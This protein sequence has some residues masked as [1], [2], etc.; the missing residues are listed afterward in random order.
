MPR[1]GRTLERSLALHSVALAGVLVALIGGF[2]TLSA[3]IDVSGAVIA[4]G[5]LVVESELKRIQHP[6]GGV[7]S[8]ILVSE[9]SRVAKDEVLL[10][11]DPTVAKA[12]L[13]AVTNDLWEL[14]ARRARLEAE[15]D[16][17][18]EPGFTPA[19]LAAASDPSL[20]S[21]VSGEKTLFRYRTEAL[22]GQKAQLR[23]RI[24]QLHDE[25]AGLQGQQE[26]KRLELDLVEKELTGIRELW[27]KKLIPSTR[28]MALERE[29]ARLGGEAGK[30]AAML[31][32]TRGKI[33]ETELQIIEIDQTARTDVA[34]QLA[35]IRAKTSELT[36][37]RATALDQSERVEIRAPQAGVVLSLSVHT[38]GGVITAGEQ[39]MQIV[40]ENDALIA[41]ARVR[42][43]DVNQIRLDQ[44]AS[45]RFSNLNQRTTP[46]IEGRVIRISADAVKD[47]RVDEPYF[48][49]RLRFDRSGIPSD[50]V[51]LPGMP[52]EVFIRTDPRS[53]ASYL[54]KPMA[55]QMRRAFRE[56]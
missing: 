6:S 36:E 34:K 21:L 48:V 3:A 20:A 43:V 4:S 46:E 14:S 38:L 28:L 24:K 23:E 7:V 31:A 35:D 22:A 8:E 56:K 39:L 19:L 29:R 55:D 30:L 49:V 26:A 45:L 40:P 51:L 53:L 54:V 9:G 12:T 2:T 27:E 15:R 11:L 10:R 16:G 47:E 37:K 1:P 42:P 32:Q 50:T 44:P 25:G 33:S 18:S 52:V 17:A 41:E 5:N 13:N